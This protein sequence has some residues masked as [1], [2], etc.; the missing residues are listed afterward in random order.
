MNLS[1]VTDLRNV[2]A[3][4]N[5]YFSP[6]FSTNACSQ[7]HGREWL[8]CHA[9]YQ[10][11]SRCLT[12]DESQEMCNTYTSAKWVWIRLPTLALKPRVDIARSPKHG[13]QWPHKKDLCPQKIKKQINKTRHPSFGVQSFVAVV[14]L[15][16]KA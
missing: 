2:S 11:V 5:F 16:I 9:G 8:S 12:R 7:V 3:L 1:T 4:W 10:E 13:Y 15:G 14:V 6:I